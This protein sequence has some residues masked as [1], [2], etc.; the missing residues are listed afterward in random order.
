MTPDFLGILSLLACKRSPVRN[1]PWTDLR[2]KYIEAKLAP[3]ANQIANRR[4][5]CQPAPHP[6]LTHY[7]TLA[8]VRAATAIEILSAPASV[9]RLLGS[10]CRWTPAVAFGGLIEAAELRFSVFGRGSLS[11]RNKSGHALQ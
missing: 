4:A 3:I 8:S 2:V 1:L 5:A 10:G 9:A 11:F 7:R 6:E